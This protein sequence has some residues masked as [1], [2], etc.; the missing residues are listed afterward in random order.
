[1][2]Q[3]LLSLIPLFIIIIFIFVFKINIKNWTKF[4]VNN[5]FWSLIVILI[6]VIISI[7]FKTIFPTIYK[8][9][10]FGNSLIYNLIFAGLIEETAKFLSLKF[11]KPNNNKEIILNGLF[12]ATF[13]SIVEHYM[14]LGSVLSNN[15]IFNRLFTPGHAFYLLFP[16]WGMIIDKKNNNKKAMT[17][18]GLLIGI[19][20][21]A[22]YDTINNNVATIIIFGI[23]GYA[24]II[25]SLYKISKMTDSI[26]VTAPN[27]AYNINEQVV[28]NTDTLYQP[29][30]NNQTFKT[31][32]IV[33]NEQLIT[34]ENNDK[35]FVLKIIISVIISLLVLLLFKVDNKLTK[36]NTY[37]Q[38]NT[39]N[40]DVMVTSSEIIEETDYY[41]GQKNKY[42]KIG[43]SIKNNSNTE[44]EINNYDFSIVKIS[45]GKSNFPTW[46]ANE[47]NR[48]NTQIIDSNSEISGYFYFE[49]EGNINEYRFNYKPFLKKDAN[50][51]I[52]ELR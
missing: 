49:A 50:K 27:Q 11:S 4:I 42:I 28:S 9:G 48:L 40:I 5:Y 41:D 6:T 13:F 18:K 3:L 15:I 37:C 38:N 34:E 19:I 26:Q 43:V 46:K 10:E 32:N 22:T 45:N 20:V 24:A 23:V 39:N 36:M 30:N 52:F 47:S 17:I 35:F 29:I 2:I 14:Y 7:I 21:H 8:T 44:Y 33:Q 31:E 16:I 51:C 25:Y 1:M 12:I